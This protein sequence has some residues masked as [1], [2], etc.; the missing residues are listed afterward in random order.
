[1]N[2]SPSGLILSKAILGFVQAKT[3]EGLSPN[4]ITG[5]EHDLKLWLKQRGDTEVGQVTTQNLREHLAWL[6]T[7][8]KPQRM[9]G[10]EHPLSSPKTQ[11]APKDTAG[12]IR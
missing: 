12:L 6:R 7:T 4:T 8:Y 5:Y 11:S 9:S 1:M 10:A 2:R 3:A